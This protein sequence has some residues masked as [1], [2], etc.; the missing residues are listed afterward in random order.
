MGLRNRRKS[1]KWEPIYEPACELEFKDHDWN[2]EHEK[3]P[4]GYTFRPQS[5]GEPEKKE[6]RKIENITFTSCDFEGDFSNNTLVFV[7][8]KFDRVDFGLTTFQ[9]AKFTNCTFDKSS[10]TQA[11]LINCELRNCTFI[12]IWASGNATEL[13]KTLI[14][15]PYDFIKGIVAYTE[16]F[17]RSPQKVK[18]QELRAGQTRATLARVVLSATTHEGSNKNFYEAVKTAT[19]FEAYEKISNGKLSLLDPKKGW[20]KLDGVFDIISGSI[21]IPV[22]KLFGFMNC[23]GR[24]LARPVILGFLSVLAFAVCYSTRSNPCDLGSAVVKSIEVFFLFGYT[25]FSEPDSY[26]FSLLMNALFGLG[27]YLITI[28]TLVNRLTRIRS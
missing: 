12:D 4:C 22:L 2:F 28:P 3:G 26:S 14:T 23:W 25:K 17:V 8:C 5:S 11:K 27:W 15:N 21:E 20:N 18:E 10:F 13:E 24:S 9:E 7:R 6:F 19:L 16:P 1:N